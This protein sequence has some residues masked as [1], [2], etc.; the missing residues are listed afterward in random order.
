MTS[1]CSPSLIVAILG[2]A[3]PCNTCISVQEVSFLFRMFCTDIVAVPSVSENPVM[4]CPA[5]KWPCCFD[6]FED[7]WMDGYGTNI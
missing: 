4:D 1:R 3:N 6:T 2:Q 7:G 5:F